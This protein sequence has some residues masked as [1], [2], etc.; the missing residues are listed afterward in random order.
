LTP[1]AISSVFHDEAGI[2]QDA[3]GVR[4]L[5]V[6]GQNRNGQIGDG[7]TTNRPA[8]VQVFGPLAG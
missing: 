7:T 3:A 4:T 1:D 8:P 6:W 5:W 2:R